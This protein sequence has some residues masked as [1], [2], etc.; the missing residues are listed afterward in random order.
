VPLLA[1]ALPALSLPSSSFIADADD[2][3]CQNTI[4]LK[5]PGPSAD[6]A[7]AKYNLEEMQRAERKVGGWTAGWVG[8]WAG[9]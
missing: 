7:V 2:N 3:L 5:L 8:G 9:R 6:A 1:R 4:N